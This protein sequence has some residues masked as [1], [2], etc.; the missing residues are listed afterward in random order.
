M[1]LS[2]KH[3]L[4]AQTTVAATD[5][6]NMGGWLVLIARALPGVLLV[7]LLPRVIAVEPL[8][9]NLS[10]VVAPVPWWPPEPLRTSECR[11]GC[12]RRDH[13]G[14]GTPSSHPRSSGGICRRRRVLVCQS[15]AACARPR[16]RS[17]RVIAAVVNTLL[18]RSQCSGFG[19]VCQGPERVTSGSAAGC[20]SDASDSA[21]GIRRGSYPSRF[22]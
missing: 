19:S 20:H 4:V 1:G 6:D 3:T 17:R 12:M 16:G 10:R 11:S 7:L 9:R 8:V 15:F 21:T 14:D 18:R 13:R 5:R 2:A 22:G